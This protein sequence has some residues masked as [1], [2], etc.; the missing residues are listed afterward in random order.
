M[1][2]KSSR[3]FRA[4]RCLAGLVLVAGLGCTLNDSDEE[5]DRARRPDKGGR[6]TISIR[7]P[8]SIEPSRAS[9]RLGLLVLK[10]ICEPLVTADP[11]TGELRPGAAASW[12]IAPDAKKVT[13]RLRPGLKFHNAR[14]VVAQ[15]YVY[16]LSRFA[17]KD[18]G[19]RQYFL[20]D[21]VGGY[22]ELRESGA[23]TLSGVKAPEAHVLEIELTEPFAELPAVLAHPG[24]GSAVPKEE[25]DKGA[26]AFAARPMCTGPYAVSAPWDRTQPLTLKRVSG[27]RGDNPAF[28]SK[29]AGVADELVFKIVADAA[30]GYEDLN[31]KQADIAEVPI[32]QLAQARKVR[33]R[34]Q[35]AANGVEVFIG[36]PVTKAPFD[37]LQFRRALALGL[38]RNEVVEKL[39]AGSREIPTGFLSPAAGPAGKAHK[40]DQTVLPSSDSKLAKEALTA[41]AV[42]PA[43][44]PLKL[45]FNAGSGHEKWLEMV[46]AHWQA[47]L[48]VAST[49]APHDP[50]FASYLDYLVE[51]ADGPFRWAWPTTYPS[52]EAIFGPTFAGGSPDNYSRFSSP[53]FEEALKKARATVDTEDRVK[54][55]TD[56]GEIL[57]NELPMLPVWNVQN[58]WA[59][60]AEVASASNKR[61][62]TFAEPILRELGRS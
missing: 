33:G 47:S 46:G 13:F 44:T 41:S 61:L 58:H 36:L 22:K 16:S 20:L 19:S 7:A 24:A 25:I 3:S 9:E 49:L 14:E 51:G 37:N 53:A 5:A 55:Y 42:D 60:A 8:E 56:A 39:L 45:H 28:S 4:I 62:D 23:A 32:D 30:A 38:D 1:T 17:H 12:E 48:G 26:E 18:T 29:G 52:P 59:F 11:S 35:S 54:A 34:V 10:Q 57:C 27:Y 6:L 43:A 21:R 31:K 50:P 40:C 2:A 15:D